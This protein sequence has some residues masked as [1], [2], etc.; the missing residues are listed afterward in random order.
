MFFYIIKHPSKTIHILTYFRFTECT[1]SIEV[2]NFISSIKTC[3]QIKIE[4][5]YNNSDQTIKLEFIID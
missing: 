5:Y 2:D 3:Y 4:T 1:F